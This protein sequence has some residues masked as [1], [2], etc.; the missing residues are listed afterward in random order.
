MALESKTNQ[1]TGSATAA[2]L[3]VTGLGFQPKALLIWAGLQQ[4]AGA[5]ADAQLSL[6]IAS[7][8]SAERSGGFNS[9]DNATSADLANVYNESN[10]IY[11]TQAGTTTLESAA[12]LSAIGADGF[13][14]SW[15]SVVTNL[16]K[17]NYLAFGGADITNTVAGKFDGKTTTG[18]TAVTG[19]GFRPDVVI[20]FSPFRTT[21]GANVLRGRV[22]Y[23]FGVA[24]DTGGQWSVSVRS[25]N[26]TTSN[27]ARSFSDSTCLQ[28]IDPSSETI[29][30]AISLVSMDSDGFTVNTDVASG[31]SHHMNYLAIKGGRWKAGTATQKTTTGT[32]ATTGVGFAPSGALF[33]SV[34]ATATSGAEAHSK[35]C[36]GATTGASNNVAQWV[37]DRDNAADTVA[38]T[39]L[40]SDKC[41]VMATETVGDAPSEE[42][43]AEL[44]T[45]DSDGF[46]LDWTSADG[47]ARI[48]GYLAWSTD[49]VTAHSK[50]LTDSV[51]A[52]DINTSSEGSFGEYGNTYFAD[53]GLEGSFT[54]SLFTKLVG[55]ARTETA[56]M[57]EVLTRAITRTL[58]SAVTM[59]STLL[60]AFNTAK[61]LTDSSTVSDSVTKLTEKPRSDS[62]TLTDTLTTIKNFVRTLTDSFTS[63]SSLVKSV[64]KVLSD[65]PTMTDA[66][67]DLKTLFRTLTDSTTVS[68]SITTQRAQLVSDSFGST[69]S[70]TRATTNLVTDESAMSDTLLIGKTLL[71]TYEDSTDIEEDFLIEKFIGAYFSDSSTVSDLL[72]KRPGKLFLE[73]TS[74]SEDI[75]KLKSY[76]KTLTDSV[77]MSEDFLA[78]YIYN[79]TL[80][81]IFTP[82]DVNTSYDGSMGEF[83]NYY[84]GE[85]SLGD[86]AMMIYFSKRVYKNLSEQPLTFTE[87]FNKCLNGFSIMWGFVPKVAAA[88]TKLVKPSATFSG[89][90]KPE[91]TFTKQEKPESEFTPGEKPSTTWSKIDKQDGC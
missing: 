30:E 90:A 84:Y 17:Y 88:F 71:R 16:L 79:R 50:N 64:G 85:A 67:T 52:T 58:T 44:D 82:T 68:S 36:I 2:A 31:F 70:I 11:L 87:V 72:T 6:G 15:S 26:G 18:T 76:N 73:A 59:T 7:S 1:A 91:A 29:E 35:L 65:S 9:V 13:T 61:A 45:F 53:A 86:V 83:G 62:S 32:K 24:D 42:A 54:N 38:A 3:A 19:L 34:G 41:L 27:T 48:F 80:T 56:T 23:S 4:S 55:K 89:S 22:V 20:F 49:G 8:T 39:I 12:N 69:D 21:G 46:T 74:M 10:I 43:V 25:Q 63:A 40:K 75:T 47:T 57:S 66:I 60:T 81:D 28:M 5:T 37:G 51:S 77:E 33:A 14:L 78:G